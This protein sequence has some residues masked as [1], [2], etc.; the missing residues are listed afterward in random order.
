MLRK[1]DPTQLEKVHK[2]NVNTVLYNNNELL[3]GVYITFT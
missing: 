3:L 2:P 1:I